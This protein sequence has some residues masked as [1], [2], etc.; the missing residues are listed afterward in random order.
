MASAEQHRC[1][2]SQDLVRTQQDAPV[3]RNIY[4]KAACTRQRKRLRWEIPPRRILAL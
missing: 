2:V 1:A 3:V 4:G